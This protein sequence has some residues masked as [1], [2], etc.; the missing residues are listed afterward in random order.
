M[1]DSAWLRSCSIL[2]CMI[3]ATRDARESLRLISVWM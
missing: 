1:F 3:C 2:M